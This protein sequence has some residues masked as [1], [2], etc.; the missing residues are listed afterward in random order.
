VNAEV[1][2][3]KRLLRQDWDP[4]GVHG[5]GPDDEYDSY[6]FQIFGMLNQGK[7]EAEIA[8]YLRRA[9]VENMG[10]TDAGDCAAIARKIVEIHE[11]EI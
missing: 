9:A 11:K 4:I 1:E 6:A 10:L 2:A 3:L 5:S 7:G 8:D